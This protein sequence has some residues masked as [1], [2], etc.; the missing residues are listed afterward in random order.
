MP[1]F[2]A[3]EIPRGQRW[4]C[5]DNLLLKTL[6]RVLF[7]RQVS[8]CLRLSVCTSPFMSQFGPEATPARGETIAFARQ[9]DG[10]AL[11]NQMLPRLL[12]PQTFAD[13]PAIAQ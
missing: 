3:H 12:C 4:P 11:A 5:V 2:T 9:H 10:L 8:P 6:L 13:Q 7:L 1:S